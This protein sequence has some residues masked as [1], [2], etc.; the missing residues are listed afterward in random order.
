MD[1][2]PVQV[3]PPGLLGFLQLKVGGLNPDTLLGELRGILDLTEWYFQ[4]RYE[5]PQGAGGTLASGPFVTGA[6]ALGYN[7]WATVGGT[8]GPLTV[9][10]GEAW[11][12]GEYTMVYSCGAVAG[13]TALA[14]PCMKTPASSVPV[15]LAN[16]TLSLT[17][18]ATKAR[19]VPVRSIGRFFAPAG[20]SLGFWIADNISPAGGI[21]YNGQIRFARLKL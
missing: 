9:P 14:V 2:K 3:I 16:P 11:M 10:N 4:A 20:S 8:A 13:D 15:M 19:S 21:L 12:V 5:E 7:D 18:S 17:G 1:S 6:A